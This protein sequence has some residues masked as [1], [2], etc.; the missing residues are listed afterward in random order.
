MG[1]S[2][3]YM[4]VVGRL[5]AVAA[6]FGGAADAHL[7]SLQYLITQHAGV[8][9]NALRCTCFIGTREVAFT[10]E[11]PL[12]WLHDQDVQAERTSLCYLRDVA[13]EASQNILA[14]VNAGAVQL[15]VPIPAEAWSILVD[16]F[17]A[18]GPIPT[19]PACVL[20]EM[21]GFLADPNHP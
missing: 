15:D 21:L 17:G 16:S 20:H 7:S 18:V 6:R 14:L 11:V 10:P 4:W 12:A 3:D 8:V 9:M 19:L 2:R 5:G 1:P 13:Q